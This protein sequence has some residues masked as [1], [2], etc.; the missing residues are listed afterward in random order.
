VD[1]GEEEDVGALPLPVVQLR[2][3]GP[4]R[5]A[6]VAV[7]VIVSQE[8]VETKHLV[9]PRWVNAVC[10]S[11]DHGW[12]LGSGCRPLGVTRVVFSVDDDGLQDGI[13]TS[14]VRLVISRLEANLDIITA[15]ATVAEVH[16]SWCDSEPL[17]GD[18]VHY[19]VSDLH[20]LDRFVV[21]HLKLPDVIKSRPISLHLY[22]AFCPGLTDMP[23]RGEIRT[24]SLV[25]G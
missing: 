21:N 3:S 16:R 25:R 11:L 9:R 22:G 24:S 17:A 12:S 10:V 7:F 5:V 18:L 2:V 1:E 14:L 6:L 23:L 20:L 19:S 15:E 4:H 13:H 8:D